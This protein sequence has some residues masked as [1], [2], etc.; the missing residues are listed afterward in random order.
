MSIGAPTTSIGGA[1][2]TVWSHEKL[3]VDCMKH[4][5]TCDRHAKEDTVLLILDCH[6][7]YL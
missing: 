3:F 5:I 6:K 2:P 4:C 7:T 1:N